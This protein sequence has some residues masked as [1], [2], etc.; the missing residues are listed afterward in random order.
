MKYWYCL[1]LFS[2]LIAGNNYGQTGIPASP[3]DKSTAVKQLAI[4]DRMPDMLIPD[5]I[6]YPT[7]MLNF[8]DLR[9]KFVILDFWDTGCTGCIEAFPKMQHLQAR[10]PKDLKIILVDLQSKS[11]IQNFL[12][13]HQKLTGFKLKLPVAANNKLLIDYFR[14]EGYP[15]FAWI[16]QQGM[17]R[18]I[19]QA[20]DVTEKN[21]EEAIAGKFLSLEFRNVEPLKYDGDKPLYVNGNGGDGK[22]IVYYS[23]LSNR[24]GE[25]PTCGG[26]KDPGESNSGIYAFG[27]PV[28]GL[29]LYAFNDFVNGYD[30]P[31]NR[32]ILNVKDTSKYVWT[33]NGITQWQNLYNYQLLAPFRSVEWLKKTEQEDLMSYFDLEAHM[34]KRVMKCWVMRA[35]DTS[36]LVSKG[37][38]RTDSVSLKD[39]NFTIRNAPD[40]LLDFRF[41]YDWFYNS[42]NPFINEIH[43]RSHADIF[44]ENIDVTNGQ[45]IARAIYDKYRISI[46]LEDHE[47]NMLIISEPGFSSANDHNP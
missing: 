23:S 28:K 10:F 46:N 11:L 15:H 8:S 27:S 17:V 45:E 35:E 16:D 41:R 9:G 20:E 4:G 25:F 3:M 40:S 33:V 34:E 21:V 39:F 13:L 36:L 44:L 37:G 2:L 14:P 19:T 26:Y 1:V 7:P 30:L 47:V 22:S 29:F 18:Y 31:D 5:M 32:A 43:M 42:P 12:A 6:N 38:Y 24:A